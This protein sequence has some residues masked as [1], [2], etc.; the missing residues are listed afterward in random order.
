M[1]ESPGAIR[2][3]SIMGRLIVGFLL[4]A[5]VSAQVPAIGWLAGYRHFQ[6]EHLKPISPVPILLALLAIGV[7]LVLWAGRVIL[8]VSVTPSSIILRRLCGR[9]VIPRLEVRRL[10]V[11]SG[12]RPVGLCLELEGR[13]EYAW[14]GPPRGSQILAL[15]ASADQKEGTTAIEIVERE[16]TKAS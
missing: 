12:A 3:I 8:S 10:V 16:L 6:D 9:T 1:R 11:N 2:W 7:I 14:P 4:L 13:S 15:I 5:A